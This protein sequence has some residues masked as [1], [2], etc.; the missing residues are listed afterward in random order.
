MDCATQANKVGLA[1]GRLEEEEELKIE[2]AKRL[3]TWKAI[4]DQVSQWIEDEGN[5][6]LALDAPLGW[7]EP[8]GKLL[9]QHEAGAALQKQT[10]P[11]FLK[12]QANRMFDRE[13]DRWIH[14]NI[15][16]KP[17]SVGADRIART[18]HATLAF[19]ERLRKKTK[20]A[21]PLAWKPEDVADV[22]VIEVYPAATL[23]G[24]GLC[25]TGLKGKKGKDKRKCVIEKLK[26]EMTLPGDVE[27]EM[28]ENDD[29]L[30]AVVCVLA[31]ADFK[32]GEATNPPNRKIAKL[33]EKEGWIWVRE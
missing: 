5:C 3:P 26:H 6:L 24:R 25:N 12:E 9:V 10:D 31:A 28:L 27:E 7:P 13:T 19:L 14:K 22:S 2:S 1:S 16:K 33:A 17:L 11:M 29:V 30:D 21:I 4:D 18:A 23:K 32:E 15:R 8:L 20:L